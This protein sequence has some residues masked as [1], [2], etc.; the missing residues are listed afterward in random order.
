MASVVAVVSRLATLAMVAL[1]VVALV[2][3]D[4][5]VDGPLAAAVY[6][7][8]AGWGAVFI[9]VVLR[10]DPVPGW[11]L[12][13][14]VCV[15]AACVAVLPSTA[16]TAAFE[17]Q[18]ANAGL[19][20]IT[21]AVAAAVSLLGVSVRR[22][23]LSCSVLAASYLAGY[24]PITDDAADAISNVSVI[25]WQVGTACCCQVFIGRLRA[26]A[27]VV[28]AATRDVVAARERVAARRAEGELRVRHFHEQVRRFR[29]LHDGPL[30]ILT[31]MAGP[32][33]AG[34]PDPA[35]RRQC[36]VSANILR[37]AAPDG[38]GGT[39]TDL[40]LALIE[41]GNAS[42][43]LG[44]RVTYHFANLP[45]DLPGEV[46]AALQAAGAEA[47]SNAAAHAGTG[48]AHLT[49]TGGGDPRRPS[50]AVAVVDQGKGFDPEHRPPGCGIRH[51]IIDRLA[52]VGGVATVDSHPGQGTRVDLRWPA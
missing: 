43:A 11:V 18:V 6:V 30:R 48:R 24:A 17:E 19:E 38:T 51:S 35:I 14:D 29:A 1:S 13:A 15:T 46:V 10:R 44:L 4:G 33:P 20:P 27:D 31:A 5:Y 41:A 12:S 9:V 21:V 52:E 50:V 49:G 16:R 39:L 25:G 34:H 2:H 8:V 23:A 40:S 37:G 28:D 45:D 26:L 7:V 3:A 32:G 42:A 47:L 22:T 36:A